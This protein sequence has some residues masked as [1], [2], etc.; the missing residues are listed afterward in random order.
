ME[1]AGEVRPMVEEEVVLGFRVDPSG[2]NFETTARS[3][4]LI[5]H[6]DGGMIMHDTE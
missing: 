3:S 5:K 6:P 2:R 1:R 4:T